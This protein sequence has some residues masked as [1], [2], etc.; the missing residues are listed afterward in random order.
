MS[1][2][3][4]N[5]GE[6]L[7]ESV[8]NINAYIAE[9]EYVISID[10]NFDLEAKIENDQIVLESKDCNLK[11]VRKVHKDLNDRVQWTEKPLDGIGSNTVCFWSNQHKEINDMSRTCDCKK[12]IYECIQKFEL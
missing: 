7:Q 1:P 8:D 11:F 12:L 10:W 6:N 4:I 3:S 5:Q 2:I 9:G